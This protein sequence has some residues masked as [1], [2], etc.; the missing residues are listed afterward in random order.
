MNLKEHN[1]EASATEPTLVT[2]DAVNAAATGISHLTTAARLPLVVTE[3]IEAVTEYVNLM[4]AKPETSTERE[5]YLTG[6]N[7]GA[8]IAVWRHL[9][10]LGY[11]AVAEVEKSQVVQKAGK[12]EESKSKK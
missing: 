8:V 10:L 4:K 11:V 9:E 3:Q 5:A 6:I 1:I 7:H 2:E 12:N